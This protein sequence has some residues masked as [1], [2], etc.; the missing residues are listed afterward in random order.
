MTPSPRIISKIISLVTD[1]TGVDYQSIRARN[2]SPRIVQARNLTIDVLNISC[3]LSLNEIGEII[4]RDHG[5][6]LHSIR[7]SA[8]L[9]ERDPK[10]QA[11]LNKLCCR[12]SDLIDTQLATI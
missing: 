2:R 9:A 5:S 6:I 7:R 4:D 8:H 10:Y 1:A 3:S 11:L 12:A